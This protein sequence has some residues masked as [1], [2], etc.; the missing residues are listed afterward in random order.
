MKTMKFKDNS[1]KYSMITKQQFLKH[2][3]RWRKLNEIAKRNRII[4]EMEKEEF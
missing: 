4:E 2:V 1:G 3:K